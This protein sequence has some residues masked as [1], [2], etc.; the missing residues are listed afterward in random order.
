MA[1]NLPA[2]S[3]LLDSSVQNMAKHLPP[4]RANLLL[5]NIGQPQVADS[6]R[7]LRPDIVPIHLGTMPMTGRTYSSLQWTRGNTSP[8]P[9]SD[10]AFDAITAHTLLSHLA[11][12][13]PFLTEA[14]RVLRPG[15]RL[16]M[17]DPAEGKSFWQLLPLAL[18][19]RKSALGLFRWY[20]QLATQRRF[21]LAPLAKLLEQQGYARILTEKTLDGWAVLSRGEKPHVATASTM[22]RVQIG[23]S[24]QDNSGVWQAAA[25]H[26]AP[27]KYIHLLIRQTPDKPAWDSQSGDIRWEAVVIEAGDGTI[28]LA[29]TSLPKAVS[30]MQAAVLNGTLIGINKIAKFSKVT[31]TTWPFAVLLNP[32]LEAVQANYRLSA[33]FI[34]IDRNSAETGD[35]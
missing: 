25:L 35:E 7:N 3:K 19:D 12:P 15:G 23:A 5:L 4:S 29:F 17:L 32:T 30:F 13:E 24:G 33:H 18:R 2:D 8:L 27:G 11:H 10:N 22:D 34:P 1:F 31:A 6:I 28:A 16:I 21:A 20:R 14:L 9:F 26:H